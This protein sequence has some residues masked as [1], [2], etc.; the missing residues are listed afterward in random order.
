MRFVLFI[1]L[2]FFSLSSQAQEN[3]SQIAKL[4]IIIDDI[5]YNIPLGEKAVALR[6]PVTLSVLPHTPGGKKLAEAGHQAGK[7]IMLH[8]PMSNISHKNLG[9]G[10]LT[11]DMSKDEFIASLRDS[12]QDIPHVSGINNHMGSELTAMQEPMNWLMQEIA[13]QHLF[14]I[15]SLTSADSVAFASASKCGIV[16]AQRDVF[17]DNTREEEAI[18][19]QLLKAIALAKKQGYAIAIGHPYPSTLK[20]L[21]S[22]AGRFIDH[23]VLITPASAVALGIRQQATNKQGHS[24]RI[25][26]NNPL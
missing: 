16:T 9:P 3:K 20:V 14:F 5:G 18:E 26:K 21:A 11:T 1:S 25:N 22:Y 8:I 2:F 10:A 23:G 7:Q 6:A 17:L 12:I 13:K 19:R 15:D 4:A 24:V